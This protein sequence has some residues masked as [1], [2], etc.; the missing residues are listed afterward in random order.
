MRALSKVPADRFAVADEFARAL[1]GESTS[2][3]AAGR[4]RARLRGGVLVGAIA[5][6]AA[7]GAIL[8]RQP[9]AAIPP[10]AAMIAVLPFSSPAGDTALVRL[11]QDLAATI[12]A[13]LDGVGDIRTAD[14]LN[15][16]A[17]FRPGDA[18]SLARAANLARR[19]G[20]GSVLRGSLV[21]SGAN[22]R[23]DVGLYSTDKLTP[24]AQGIALT[25][26]RDSMAALTDSVVWSLLSQIWLR[27]Q[28]P[29]PSLAAVT[30]RSL[31]ALRAFLDGERHFDQ[32]DMGEASLA[33]RSA[34]TADSSFTLA[35]YRYV[36]AR[37][38][39]P[40]EEVEPQAIEVLRRGAGSLAQRERLMVRAFL[41]DS[42]DAKVELL[43]EV[44]R[45][46][47]LYWPGWLLLGDLFIHYAPMGGYDWSEG[48]VALRRAVELHPRL[49]VGWE[50]I[51]TYGNGRRQL[52]ADTA[53]IRA[54][55]LGWQGAGDLHTR[56]T[57]GLHRSGGVIGPELRGMADSLVRQYI[58]DPVEY[59]KLYGPFS[60]GFLH[61][62]FPAAQIELSR[63][64][65]EWDPSNPGPQLRAGMAWAHAARG[66]WDSA[67]SAM[68]RLA[69]TN[70]G[71]YVPR[72]FAEFG[73]PVLAV[74]SYGLA[75]LGSWLGVVPAETADLGRPGAVA[76]VGRLPDRSRSAAEVRMAWFDGLLGFARG[77]RRAILEARQAA[78]R[79]GHAQ[80]AMVEG[81]LTMLDRA[82]GGDI[83]GAGRSLAALEWSCLAREECSHSTPEI[84]VQRLLAARWLQE[85][86]EVEEA[87]RLLRWFD[88]AIE[89]PATPLT[90]GHVLAGP[91][92]MARARLE[93]LRG[94][95][96]RAVEYYRYFLR[97]YDQPM[98]SQ[99]HLVQE[100]KEALA[101]LG[102]DS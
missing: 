17:D 3:A 92:Y 102:E 6:T 56:L 65:L 42:L 54:K 82:L 18:I 98:P 9:R 39:F 13:S 4:R 55:E 31:P 77:N 83:A 25:A 73:D 70:P 93:E 85:S 101:R 43:R 96:R 100:A 22:V 94:E 30:T 58:E 76:S 87:T 53:L 47:P 23:L 36:I 63:R 61:S 41:A 44:T 86:G 15:I 21:Q 40:D 88:A 16:A 57:Q 79:S 7:L 71:T 45:R 90:I 69:A 59:G 12:S 46:F 33:Y 51:F 80:S 24:L 72:R 68:S 28:P 10:S 20:A 84:A 60:V 5:V 19:L 89:G 29:S 50:H 64:R 27:G 48:L 35:Y 26:H 49:V 38:W 66:S 37:S 78:E 67:V 75:V 99:A 11:G 14:R 81:S 52:V 91:T 32:G 97:V 1:Q 8:L 95:R 2:S 74:E 62:G 34:M